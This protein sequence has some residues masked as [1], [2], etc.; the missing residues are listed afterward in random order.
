[1]AG[2][3]DRLSHTSM[4]CS[5]GL[6]VIDS[7]AIWSPR[8]SSPHLSL[9]APQLLLDT[10]NYSHDTKVVDSDFLLQVATSVELI[11]QATLCLNMVVAN[12]F[13]P[14]NL[15]YSCQT[16]LEVWQEKCGK[17]WQLHLVTKTISCGALLRYLPN[18]LPN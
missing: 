15:K 5:T 9:G 2:V 14:D 11:L 6:P 18:Y 10:L 8:L 16:L 1:M 7:G 13:D 4:H 12:N 17:I 3:E